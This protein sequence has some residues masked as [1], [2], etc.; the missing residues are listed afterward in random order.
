MFYL[1]PLT[2]LLSLIF[3]SSIPR[4]PQIVPTSSFYI[5][6]LH[7]KIFPQNHFTSREFANL[8]FLGNIIW[9]FNKNY[10]NRNRCKTY[11]G[12]EKYSTKGEDFRR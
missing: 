2:A 8:L 10:V 7:Y 1:L 11:V 4:S 9:K 12:S 3:Y 6:L 5:K